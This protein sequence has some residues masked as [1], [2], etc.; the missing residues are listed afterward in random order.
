MGFF[1]LKFCQRQQLYYNPAPFEKDMIT[2]TLTLLKE[3]HHFY[4]RF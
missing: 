2:P 4:H 3:S 1:Y